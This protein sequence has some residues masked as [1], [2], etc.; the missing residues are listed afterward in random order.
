MNVLDKTC[1]VLGEMIRVMEGLRNSQ[2]NIDSWR[3]SCGSTACV[4]G[5][6]AQDEWFNEQGFFWD[7]INKR[8]GLIADNH[9]FHGLEA[10]SYMICGN[11]WIYEDE[12]TYEDVGSYLFMESSYPHNKDWSEVFASREDVIKRLKMTLNYLRGL[13]EPEMNSSIAMSLDRII[14]SSVS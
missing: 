13:D 9:K 2:F 8:P 14:A 5:W 11:E 1:Q 10:F 7:A 6:C 4:L 12:W 3:S